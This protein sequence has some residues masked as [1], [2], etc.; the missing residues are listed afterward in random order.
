MTEL[1]SSDEYYKDILELRSQTHRM[2]TIGIYHFHPNDFRDIGYILPLTFEKWT[3]KYGIKNLADFKSSELVQEIAF[4]EKLAKIWE[5]LKDCHHYE[6]LV[7]KGITITKSGM[8]TAGFYGPKD[9]VKKFLSS[10]GQVD[11][12]DKFKVRRCSDYMKKFAG[13]DIDYSIGNLDKQCREE[14]KSIQEDTVKSLIVSLENCADEK[15]GELIMALKM[16][17][18]KEFAILMSKY[19]INLSQK[20]HEELVMLQNTLSATPEIILQIIEQ[21]HAEIERVFK[22]ELL[23]FVHNTYSKELAI[24]IISED[25]LRDE[26]VEISKKLNLGEMLGYSKQLG[27]AGI[28]KGLEH[29]VQNIRLKKIPGDI[30]DFIKKNVP[31]VGQKLDSFALNIEKGL[32]SEL[33][34]AI[35]EIIKGGAFEAKFYLDN[36]REIL[37]RGCVEINRYNING[38]K[39]FTNV[40]GEIE[41]G[42][43]KWGEGVGVTKSD[44][45]DL[46]PTGE[47]YIESI[48]G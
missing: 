11:V 16:E 45:D 44:Q 34:G 7:I 35:T 41:N 12:M 1:K 48:I 14:L 37:E 32:T 8:I 38:G 28:I 29:I 15:K 10:C 43:E 40:V 31:Q 9:C 20:K 3:G 36:A 26:E 5:E 2:S 21:G 39:D 46:R 17:L 19:T 33:K 42:C 18:F 24:S 25:K 30:K 27:D 13:Y 47:F 22:R 23:K 6:G 4:R